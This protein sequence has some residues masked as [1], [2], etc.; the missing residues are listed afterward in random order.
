M[1]TGRG[2]IFTRRRLVTFAVASAFSARRRRGLRV[3][4]AFP[5]RG[6]PGSAT[7]RQLRTLRVMQRMAERRGCLGPRS[8]ASWRGQCVGL[9]AGAAI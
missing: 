8:A 4:T 5:L 9:M 6:I 3:R 7:A 2:R 1:R